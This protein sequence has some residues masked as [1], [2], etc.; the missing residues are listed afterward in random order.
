[1]DNVTIS[2]SIPVPEVF[3]EKVEAQNLNQTGWKFLPNTCDPEKYFDVII[4]PDESLEE[5]NR[6]LSGGSISEF[7]DAYLV[8]ILP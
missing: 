5:D 3:L 7:G 8:A 6:H 2:N 4:V 1:M